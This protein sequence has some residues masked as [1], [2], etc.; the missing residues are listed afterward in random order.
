MRRPRDRSVADAVEHGRLDVPATVTGGRIAPSISR[1]CVNRVSACCS[2]T[3][4]ALMAAS[5][6]L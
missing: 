2:L 6:F 4:T 3:A 1:G 5:G